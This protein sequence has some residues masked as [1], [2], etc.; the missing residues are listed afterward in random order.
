VPHAHTGSQKIE[1]L[2]RAPQQVFENSM[3]DANNLSIVGQ[4]VLPAVR[5]S[6]AADPPPQPD[7]DDLQAV[8]GTYRS[9]R[10]VFTIEHREGLLWAMAQNA[11]EEQTSFGFTVGQFWRIVDVRGSGCETRPLRAERL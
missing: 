3:G 4:F 7:P 8:V 11:A 5:G 2:P 1:A 9:G 10:G 6:V